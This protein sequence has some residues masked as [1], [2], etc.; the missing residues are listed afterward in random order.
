MSCSVRSGGIA[1][2]EVVRLSSVTLNLR[3]LWLDDSLGLV[4]WLVEVQS[5]FLRQSVTRS[6]LAESELTH[7]DTQI[8]NNTHTHTY[9]L[10]HA[11]SALN[12]VTPPDVTGPHRLVPDGRVQTVTERVCVG[13]HDI[14]SRTRPAEVELPVS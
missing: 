8:P 2:A 9:S 7:L 13:G 12:V 1:P 14:V 3:L 11:L 5:F 10:S 4:G 6:R